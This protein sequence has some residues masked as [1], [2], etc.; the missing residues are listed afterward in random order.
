VYR[1][2]PTTSGPTSSS[3]PQQGS[4]P[5]SHTP[6]HRPMR[7]GRFATVDQGRPLVR[8]SGSP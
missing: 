5:G 6:L 4:N 3:D 1:G 8:V 2:L 7:I